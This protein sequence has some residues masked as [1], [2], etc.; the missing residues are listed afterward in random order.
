MGYAR[1]QE[2]AER[3][4]AEIRAAGGQAITVQCDLARTADIEAMD[5][6]AVV[7][8]GPIDSLVNNAAVFDFKALPDIDERIFTT[9]S[10]PMCLAADDDQGRRR[11]FQLRRRKRDQHQL[12]VCSGECAGQRNLFRIQGRSECNHQGAGDQRLFRSDVRRTPS[13]RPS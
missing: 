3:V 10:K 12:P 13:N 8:F 1:D 11:E 4:A 2:G 6:R 9:S 7:T 5:A